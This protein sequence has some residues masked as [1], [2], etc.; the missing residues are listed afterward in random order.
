MRQ[1]YHQMEVTEESKKY[2]TINIQRL[3][4][5]Q[6]ARF[7]GHLLLSD[8][9]ACH[10]QVLQGVPDT[11]CILNDMIITCKTDEEHLDSSS[12]FKMQVL[13][14][15]KRSASF[16]RDRVQ[17]CGHEI[18]SEGLHKMQEKI[19]AVANTPRPENVTQLCIL[20]TR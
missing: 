17:F 20:R 3:L 14:Q 12:N 13:K 8:L 1:A 6:S 7:W 15:T 19:E 9:A 10:S 11:Q 16:F 18:D 4:P 5:I 2:L